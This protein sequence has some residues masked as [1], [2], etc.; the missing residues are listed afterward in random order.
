MEK[1][2]TLSQIK[3]DLKDVQWRWIFGATFAVFGVTQIVMFFLISINVAR[4][5]AAGNTLS[6]EEIMQL[7][8][9][10][11]NWVGPFVFWG[12][13]FAASIWM[14]IKVRVAPRT[15]GWVLGLILAVLSWVLDA[16]F[17][18]SLEFYEFFSNLLVIPVAWF[19]A[20]RGEIIL[21]S[22]EAVYRTSQAIR[23]AD[24]SGIGK[25]VGEQLAG[26][27]VTLIAFVDNDGNVDTTSAWTSS[28]NQKI[29]TSIPSLQISSPRGTPPKAETVLRGSDLSLRESNILSLLVLPLSQV[30]ETLVIGSRSR[31]GFT[32]T[33]IQNYLTIAEQVSL[34][35]ENLKLIEQAH[36]TGI[37]EERQRLAAEIH[38]SL[39]Q[40][41]I[42]IV[43]LTEIAEAKLENYPQE[44]RSDF[45]SLLNQARQTARDNLTAARKMTWALR[46]DL[47][48][49][50]P[51]AD[52]LTKLGRRWSDATNIIVNISSPGDA[53]QL[54][55]DIETTLLRTAR[56]ALNNI[57]KH[58]DATQVSI[59]LTYMDTLVALD[60]QDNGKGFDVE[61]GS[62]SGSDGGFGLKSI[63]EQIKQL[64]GEL[65]VESKGNKGTT[66][67]VSLPIL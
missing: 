2:K 11:G 61:S 52:A 58:A 53:R 62:P 3:N 27:L 7:S 28:S 33:D 10:L 56:E 43:T 30:D 51:L 40:G 65:T 66:I 12:L 17:S 46:P 32:R 22:R 57:Q 23:G 13:A 67:A 54:H 60:V 26:S 37:N 31:D 47:Q 19:A 44:L 41:F 55:P 34:S 20:N 35:L 5:S 39:T 6:Q 21:K 49:G 63:D 16:V 15:H 50:K 1:Q 38:D 45:Q 18:P 9:T 14:A 36:L 64:G 8:D 25:A 4:S 59:T 42:S 24:R 48:E 29:P